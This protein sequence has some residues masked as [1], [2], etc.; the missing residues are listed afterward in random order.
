VSIDQ[1]RSQELFHKLDRLL[2]KTQA[3][4]QPE[5]VHQIRTTTRRVEAL[6][7]NLCP[8]PDRRLKKLRRRLKKLRRGAGAV[9]DVDVQMDALRTVKIGRDEERKNRLM[10]ALAE[11]RAQREQALV[12][13]LQSKKVRKLRKGLAKTPE[14]L[15]FPSSNSVDRNASGANGAGEVGPSRPGVSPSQIAEFQPVA[16][17]LRMFARLARK[18]KALTADNLH[19]Y[20]T[21]CKRI[22]YVVEIA[23]KHQPAAR[24]AQQL[25]RIQDAIGEWHD[26][27]TLTETADKV[28]GRAE[29]ALMS[30]LRSMTHGKF[31]EAR[32]ITQEASRELQR[33]YRAMQ[34]D[35]R[36]RRAATESKK[37]V[38]R[39]E[40]AAQRKAA[41]G[42]AG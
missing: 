29:N 8:H 3:K 18:T 19:A 39:V 30:A 2:A 23:G 11:M 31:L 41:A 5:R 26:W 13:S 25:K 6:I 15:R 21:E 16:T 37:P 34:A 22:R 14:T 42:Y 4:P 36:K 32:G 9:R 35:D 40:A 1:A 20:R 33:E 38:A 24:I 12:E 28:V 17:A 27:L 7:D 10:Q